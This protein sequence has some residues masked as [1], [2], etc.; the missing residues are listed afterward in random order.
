[1]IKET[2]FVSDNECKIEQHIEPG[3]MSFIE[4]ITTP[5]RVIGHPNEQ[6][7]SD[8]HVHT[9]IMAVGKP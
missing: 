7:T 9:K 8:M 5:K 1:M 4:K 3:L 2:L 6:S